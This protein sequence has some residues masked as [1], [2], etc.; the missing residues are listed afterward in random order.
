MPLYDYSCEKCGTEFEVER[1]LGATGAVKCPN[2][3]SLKTVK[4]FSAS[5]IVFK[6]SGF[7]VTDSKSGS[8]KKETTGKPVEE[9]AD[10]GESKPAESE[11]AK[12]TSS[13]AKKPAAKNKD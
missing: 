9:K 8:E 4:I 1:P 7:Y 11:A 5:G 12:S 2:C 13:E 3:G 6:G 10:S